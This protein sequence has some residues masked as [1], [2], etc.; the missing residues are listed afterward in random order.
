[1]HVD[2]ATLGIIGDD[3]EPRGVLVLA[4]RAPSRQRGHVEQFSISAVDMPWLLVWFLSSPLVPAICRYDDPARF[5]QCAPVSAA[6]LI[7]PGIGRRPDGRGRA[8]R[9]E[10]PPAVI[11]KY[12]SALS[13]QDRPHGAWRG[14]EEQLGVAAAHDLLGPTEIVEYPVDVVLIESAAHKNNDTA[15]PMEYTVRKYSI[16]GSVK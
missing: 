8:W 9:L 6:D 12:G 7:Q 2:H 5:Q 14:V 3:G 16:H 13:V 1:M 15:F 10:H 11:E 4:G